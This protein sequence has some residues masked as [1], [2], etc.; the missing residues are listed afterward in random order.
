MTLGRRAWHIA[1]VMIVLLMLLSLRLVYWPLLRTRDLQPVALDALQYADK[2]GEE[3][4]AA[5]TLQDLPQPVIQRTAQRLAT[6]T[7]GAV[8]DRNG[9][10]LAYEPAG[11]DEMPA[12]FYTEPSLAHT[13]GYVSGLRAGVA[14]IEYGENESLLGLDRL[15][16]QLSQLVHQPLMG[17]N[18]YLTID[19]RVQRTAAQAL[20]DRPGAVVALDAHTGAVLAMVSSPRFDPNQVLNEGYIRSLIDSCGGAPDCS[21]PFLNRATQGLY[22]PGS[23]WKTVTLLAALDT[24]QVTK[25]TVFDFGEPRQGASGIYYVYPVD[26]FEIQDPNHKERK[27]DLM[28][29]YM[30][31][32]NAAFARMADEMDPEVLLRY[33]SR[34][35]FSDGVANR[36]PIE[37]GASASLVA[38]NPGDLATNNVLR[39]STGFGQGEL[40]ASP[41]SMALVAA[42]VVNDGDMPSP[43]LI[44]AVHSPSGRLL[45]GESQRDW[46]SNVVK[47]STAQLAREMMIAVVTGGSGGA[48]TVPGLTVGGKTGTAQLDG[49]QAPH[50]WFIGFAEQGGRAVAIAVLVEHGGSGAQVAAPIFARVAEAALLHLG[51]PVEE[52]VPAP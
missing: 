11:G 19:S 52:V 44:Q 45:H 21:T 3:V 20:G 18:I 34:F 33:A 24:G 2:E 6:I 23:T 22:S 7:R 48:A 50:A 51:E 9:R 35:G 43:H 14:G 32:A 13:I 39:A 16:G 8:Y 36:P 17:S 4:E 1:S 31:S 25:D 15:D 41:L 5:L 30:V 40:L 49:N 42:T 26:G 28:H 29:A 38:R 37:I 10:V 46:V 47:S 27:L 12:R